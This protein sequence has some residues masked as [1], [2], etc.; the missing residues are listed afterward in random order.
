MTSVNRFLDL[1]FDIF[2]VLVFGCAVFIVF[3]QAAAVITLNKDLAIWAKKLI[4]LNARFGVGLSLTT[5]I[6]GYIR[7]WMKS[8]KSKN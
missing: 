8:G 3:S 6:M 5:L 7:G 2:L 4:V 1:L